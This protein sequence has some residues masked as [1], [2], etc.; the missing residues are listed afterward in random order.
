MT[1]AEDAK[2]LYESRLRKSLEATNCGDYVAIEPESGA[3]FV[4]PTFLAAALAAKD[5]CPNEKSFVLR[6]GQEAAFHIGAA[7]K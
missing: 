5:A 4:G 2:R 7:A 3:H 6:I 1:L